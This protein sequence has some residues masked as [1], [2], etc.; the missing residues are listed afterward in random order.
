MYFNTQTNK[1]V[2]ALF[3]YCIRSMVHNKIT[4]IDTKQ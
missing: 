3:A 4:E 1:A 2:L